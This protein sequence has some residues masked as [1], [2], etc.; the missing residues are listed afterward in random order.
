MRLNVEEKFFTPQKREN[1]Y[2]MKKKVENTLDNPL[3]VRHR[4]KQ[5]ISREKCDKNK[6]KEGFELSTLN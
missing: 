6:F 1:F 4:T 3:D 2:I 5:V